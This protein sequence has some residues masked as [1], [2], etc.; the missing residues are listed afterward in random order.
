MR[1]QR[2]ASA[3]KDEK[4]S[5]SMEQH[6]Q[7]QAA[8]AMPEPSNQKRLEPIKSQ[9]NFAEKDKKVNYLTKKLRNIERIDAQ[10]N[11]H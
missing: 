5:W 4:A 1:L 2:L 10:K 9:L 7:K 11:S 8:Q 3:M 6:R